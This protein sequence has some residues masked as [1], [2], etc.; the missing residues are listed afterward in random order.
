V[1]LFL[2]PDRLA[3]IYNLQ[4]S[5]FVIAI[6]IASTF[7]HAGWNL[8][9]RYSG[10][11]G[12]FYKQML[13]ITLIVG[14]LPAVISE[15]LT[16]SMTRLAWICVIASGTCA[17]FY[18]FGLAR[19]FDLSDFTIVYPVA[20]ALPVIIIA[21]IDVLRGRYLSPLGWMGI[22]LVVVGSVLIPQQ[23]FGDFQLRNYL[24]IAVLW[25]IVAAFGTVGYTVLD[26]IAAEVVQSGPA[27]AARYGYFYFAISFF[28]YMLLMRTVKTDHGTRHNHSWFLSGIGAVL[29][30]GAYWLILWAFQLSQVTSYIVAFRQFSIVIGAILGFIIFKEQGVYVRISGAILITLGLIVIG[31]WGG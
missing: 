17:A 6:V 2:L 23:R 30:F 19:A 4:V 28:P 16:G 21:I 9:A 18:L 3:S 10:S 15:L 12:E 11:E 20:R 5:G 8:L 27:T 26:K 25:M 13:V 1:L 24:N 7:M 31:F 14:F 22:I 29:G